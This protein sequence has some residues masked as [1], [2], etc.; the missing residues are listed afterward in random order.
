MV[1][2]NISRYW[3]QQSAPS[4]GP[5]RAAG[6]ASSASPT[7]KGRLEDSFIASLKMLA[8]NLLADGPADEDNKPRDAGVS[9]M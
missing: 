3:S 6:R 4:A 5:S 7:K 1:E 8:V 2:C 9:F